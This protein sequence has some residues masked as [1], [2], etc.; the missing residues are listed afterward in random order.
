MWLFAKAPKRH[1]SRIY[2][3]HTNTN[4]M[5][6]FMPGV[7]TPTWMRVAPTFPG[8]T[9]RRPVNNPIVT[10][11]PYKGAI[12]FVK[13]AL[14]VAKHGVALK[15]PLSFMEP[16]GDRATWL[17]ENSPSVCVFLRRSTYTPALVIVGEFWGVWYKGDNVT[18]G[19][20]MVFCP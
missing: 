6:E 8:S 14:E 16:C 3:R 12:K 4:Y 20:R 17:K 7:R 18:G 11:P 15:L 10:S 13:A 9:L 1:R 2:P 5:L 19:T